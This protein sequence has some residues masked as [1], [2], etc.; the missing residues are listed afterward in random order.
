M[1]SAAQQALLNRWLSGASVVCDHSWGLVGTTVLELAWLDQEHN[2]A[3]AIVQRTRRLIESWPTPPAVLVPTHGDWQPRNW[4]VHEGVVTVIDFGRAAL[5][6]AYT[7]FERLAAQQFL[8][9]PSLEPAFLAGYGT[10]PREREAWPRAQLREAVGTAVYAFRV[11]DGEFERQ[12][13]RMVAD[14]LRAFPD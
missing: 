9:D 13:H 1:I 11:G 2:I 6:P 5:R 7:D 8:A 4:L 3:P 14:A 12:G 10:D